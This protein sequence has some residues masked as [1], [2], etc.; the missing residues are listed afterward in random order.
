MDGESLL[1]PGGR[2]AEQIDAE[3]QKIINDAH[4]LAIKIIKEHKAEVELIAQTL[5][6]YEQITAEEIDYL[7]EHG[8]L[9]REEIVT[10]KEAEIEA[11][12]EAEVEAPEEIPNEE[13]SDENKD[14]G[15]EA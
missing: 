13:P 7:L 11:P 3:V 8:H 1:L 10:P 15:G 6:K 5:L 9:K 12:K 14:K 2:A 4:E